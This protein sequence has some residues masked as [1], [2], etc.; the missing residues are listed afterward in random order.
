MNCALC[1]KSKPSWH[2]GTEIRLRRGLLFFGGPLLRFGRG[3]GPLDPLGDVY[4]EHV[5][6][7]DEALGSI[8]RIF[9]DAALMILRELGRGG[10]NVDHYFP[11]NRLQF[12]NC[13]IRLQ[14]RRL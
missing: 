9:S 6:E 14:K 7:R 5:E 12:S 2:T 11:F 1:F 13:Q 3:F 4:R 10:F 8:D